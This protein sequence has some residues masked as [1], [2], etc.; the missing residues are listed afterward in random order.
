M[1]CGISR[2]MVNAIIRETVWDKEEQVLP[3]LSGC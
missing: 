3:E 1:A 2:R